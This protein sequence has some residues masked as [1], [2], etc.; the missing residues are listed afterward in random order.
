M[1]GDITVRAQ[2]E[3]IAD[4]RKLLAEI[5]ALLT[6]PPQSRE[7]AILL[8]RVRNLVKDAVQVEYVQTKIDVEGF[9]RLQE[10]DYMDFVND[11]LR[12]SLG[13]R[14]VRVVGPVVTRMTD[15]GDDE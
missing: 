3:I 7:D 5:D 4:P 1:F 15:V 9:S 13:E 11:K 12:Q 8:L 2:A 6:T 10:D 14:L